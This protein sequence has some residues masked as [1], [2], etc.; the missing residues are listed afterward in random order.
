M[1]TEVWGEGEGREKNLKQILSLED[2]R[3]D[4]TTL[5]S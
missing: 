2:V 3:L 1:Q 4:F 5:I